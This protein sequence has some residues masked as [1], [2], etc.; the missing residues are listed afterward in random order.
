MK[1]AVGRS[2]IVGGGDEIR[3]DSDLSKV[4]RIVDGR[5][6]VDLDEKDR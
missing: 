3:D 2:C 1:R 6:E 5:D 4:L